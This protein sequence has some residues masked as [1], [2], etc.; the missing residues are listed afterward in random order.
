MGRPKL[1]ENAELLAIAR[2][3]F[4]DAGIG[5]ST[6]EI[7]RRAGISE[8]VIYRR[9]DT[10]ADFFFAAM[11]PP[12]MDV[13]KLLESPGPGAD[14]LNHLEDIALELT[15]Y[16]RS[17]IPILLPLMTHPSFDFEDFSRRNPASPLA[18]LR[19]QLVDYLN[20]AQSRGQLG[21]GDMDGAVLTLVSTAHSLALF[22]RLGVHGGQFPD[23]MVRGI[24]H[25]L[26]RGIAPVGQRTD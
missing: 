18:D 17:L 5:G 7:A 24:V 21:P 19:D 10:K 16:F 23:F 9:F 26:W 8:A 14:M 25:T 6:R 20:A 15:T 11:V 13:E 4:V 1:I 12:A 3:V 22:E 2:D